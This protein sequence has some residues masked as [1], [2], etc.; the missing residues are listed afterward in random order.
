[1]AKVTPFSKILALLQVSEGGFVDDKRDPGS[2]TKHGITQKTYYAY[3]SGKAAAEAERIAQESLARK[4]V[5]ERDEKVS[6]MD[7]DRVRAE[8]D[9]WVRHSRRPLHRD[10]PDQSDFG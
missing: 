10:E 8:L 2:R 5:D 9:R 7:D 6:S 4:K 3:A 1:M